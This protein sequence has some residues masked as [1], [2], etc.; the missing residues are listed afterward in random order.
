KNHLYKV[1]HPNYYSRFGFVPSVNY[2]ITSEYDV[3]EEVFMI[4]EIRE[5]I[6]DGCSGIVSY[7]QAFKDLSA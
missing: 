6:L 2:G 4:Q 3:S 1:G 5:G 7:H